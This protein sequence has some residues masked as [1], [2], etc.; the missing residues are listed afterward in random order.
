MLVHLIR[1]LRVLIDTALATLANYYL[2]PCPSDQIKTHE[3]FAKSIAFRPTEE[4]QTILKV[5]H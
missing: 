3:L 5:A 4:V 1:A 2:L